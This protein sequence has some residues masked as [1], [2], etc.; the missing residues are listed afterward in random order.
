[1][2]EADSYDAYLIALLEAHPSEL[3][4]DDGAGNG[5]FSHALASLGCRVIALDIS[6]KLLDAIHERSNTEGVEIVRADMRR[7]PFQP[8]IFD[9]VLCVHNLWYI[10][11]L[12][13]AVEEIRRV[14]RRGGICVGDHLNVLDLSRYL[15][16]RFLG[17]FVKSMLGRSFVD[18]GRSSRTFT[19]PFQQVKIRTHSVMSYSPLVVKDGITTFA[20]RF[21]VV[22][23][24]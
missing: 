6:S 18:M 19:K 7:L 4:L 8:G 11:E 16:W 10:K 12:G 3:V 5:R 17:T 24:A 22:A 21:I 15:S 2:P 23:E 13:L 20:K 14:M 9:R 1:M